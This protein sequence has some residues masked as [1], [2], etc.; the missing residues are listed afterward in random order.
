MCQFI[1]SSGRRAYGTLEFFVDLSFVPVIVHVVL[2]L[3][4]VTDCYPSSVGQNIRDDTDSLLVENFISL[5]SRRSV[6]QLEDDTGFDL[7]GIFFGELVLQCCGDEDVTLLDEEFFVGD[8]ISSFMV[9][10]RFSFCLESLDLLQ[11]DTC[12]IVDSSLAV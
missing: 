1:D 7:V 6:G 4:E 10:D 12:W 8:L 5:R 3:F 9:D 2:D 11:I